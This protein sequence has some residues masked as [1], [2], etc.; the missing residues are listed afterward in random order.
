MEQSRYLVLGV[1][2]Q[3]WWPEAPVISFRLEAGASDLSVM[4]PPA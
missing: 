3:L 2:P 4:G 1:R